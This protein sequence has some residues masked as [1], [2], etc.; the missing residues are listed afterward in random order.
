MV[1]R[2]EHQKI[3]RQKAKNFDVTVRFPLKG[4]PTAGGYFVSFKKY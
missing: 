3:N 4:N 1:L 2:E